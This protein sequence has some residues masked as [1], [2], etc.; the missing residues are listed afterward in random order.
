MD[1]Q[2]FDL[3]DDTQGPT[4]KAVGLNRRV[5]KDLNLLQNI[6]LVIRPNEFVVVVGQSGGGKSTLVDALA[7]Y[8]PA[9]EGKVYV[10]DVDVYKNFDAIRTIVGYVPQRDIIH[11]ELT[12]Y[13][14]LDYAAQLRMPPSAT[15]EERHTR[16]IEVLKDL[17]LEHR[18][19]I[20][21]S[22]LS[23]GQQKR[24][25]I[26]VE[27]LTRPKL[28]FLDEPRIIPPPSGGGYRRDGR[29]PNSSEQ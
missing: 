6:S 7:G 23:G 4:I 26:G 9:S 25:S 18:K 11:L 19:D 10:D 15:A 17:D 22:R 27:L 3:S 20:Q 28:F 5:R 12:I 13:Q 29:S 16:I 8:R 14:A 24:V 1:S 21:V 2:G